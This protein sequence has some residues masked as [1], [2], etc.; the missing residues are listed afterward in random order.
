[1]CNACIVERYYLF[2]IVGSFTKRMVRLA[3][4]QLRPEFERMAGAAA[5]KALESKL[6][7]VKDLQNELNTKERELKQLKLEKKILQAK[8]EKEKINK[9]VA[10]MVDAKERNIK[11]LETDIACLQ[12]KLRRKAEELKKEKDRATSEETKRVELE[13]ALSTE[14]DRL[15]K[16]LD[17]VKG[18]LGQLRSAKNVGDEETKKLRDRERLLLDEIEDLRRQQPKLRRKLIVR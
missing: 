18:H 15:K 13:T 10:E 17:R 5:E 9:D 8:L 1:M 3:I 2:S 12:G 7:Q 16:E 14:I 11:R 6:H 4:E